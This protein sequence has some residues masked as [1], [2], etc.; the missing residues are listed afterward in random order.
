MEFVHKFL[1]IFVINPVFDPDQEKIMQIRPY[2]AALICLL[3]EFCCAGYKGLGDT[4]AWREVLHHA[5]VGLLRRLRRHRQRE[6][7]REVHAGGS[8]QQI[9]IRI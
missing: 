8:G 1:A 5:R 6:P 7:R 9:A 3:I 4:E 2:P